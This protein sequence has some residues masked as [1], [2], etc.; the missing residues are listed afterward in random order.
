MAHVL[1]SH[2]C[3][4]AWR[5]ATNY[6]LQNGDGGNL[7]VRVSN[8]LTFTEAELLSLYATGAQNKQDVMDVTNTIFPYRLFKRSN[9]LSVQAFYDKH[10]A[11]YKRG[12]KLH[13]KNKSKWGNYFLRFTS[14][15]KDGKN[16][17]Q[18]IIDRIN[19]RAKK[20]SACYMM[21]VSSPDLDNN[22]R[23]MANPC[24][25]YV[26]FEQ[27][28]KTINM[29]AVYRNHDFNTKALGNY[30]GLSRL[31]EFV[32][33]QTGCNVGSLTCH[34]IHYYLK[35]QRSVKAAIALL[36]W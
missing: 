14:F 15:G 25:Q 29:T 5:D 9:G 2:T 36:P 27:Q 30:I 31:L 24:L 8:P 26:Q 28:G 11:L 6:I 21:H 33:D 23:N 22:T 3:L 10:L 1:E 19:E 12:K 7:L 17:L 4:T 20:Y 34:S 32:C 18:N 35:N 13:T 16:Q